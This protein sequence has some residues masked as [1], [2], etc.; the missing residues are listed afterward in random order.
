META[1]ITL[2]MDDEGKPITRQG[3][4][5][6]VHV[7]KVTKAEHD[8]TNDRKTVGAEQPMPELNL[9]T[10]PHAGLIPPPPPLAKNAHQRRPAAT[11]R[12]PDHVLE[13][14][15]FLKASKKAPIVTIKERSPSSQCSAVWNEVLEKPTG[16]LNGSTV[17]RILGDQAPMDGNHCY[18]S[19]ENI[20]P[21]QVTT[22]G[23]V[24]LLLGES[25]L[26]GLEQVDP[27]DMEIESI[28]RLLVPEVPNEDSKNVL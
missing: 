17:E 12:V 28:L 2:P 11:K 27:N 10:L 18:L 19:I 4:I 13:P 24:E 25:E 21:N 5:T 1:L 7:K 6:Q 9:A 15:P 22:G 26:I 8:L 14:S 23:F 20:M 16:S 3:P